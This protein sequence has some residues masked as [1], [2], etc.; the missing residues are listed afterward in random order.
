MVF[1]RNSF[2][3]SI[4]LALFVGSCTVPQTNWFGIKLP[5][6]S[7]QVEAIEGDSYRLGAISHRSIENCQVIL[8]NDEPIYAAGNPPG[9]QR[10]S[11]AEET[12]QLRIISVTAQDEDGQLVLRF[13]DVMHKSDP[14]SRLAYY[15]IEAG[16]D[17]TECMTAFRE[18]LIN[19]NPET[20]PVLLIPQG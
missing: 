10:S 8:V 9:W 16:N 1:K 3:I 20:F 15:Q 14:P 13:Y 17:P 7:W 18:L 19:I 5:L 2:W 4:L 11:E 12:E 6:K